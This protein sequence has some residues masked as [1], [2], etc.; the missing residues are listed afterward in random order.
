MVMIMIQNKWYDENKINELYPEAIIVPPQKIGKFPGTR[1]ITMTDVY[2]NGDYFA[3]IKKDGYCYI[4]NK[5]SNHSYLFS[6]T[7]SRTTGLPSEKG[8][9]VPHIMEYLDSVVPSNTI[10]IG[11]IY[12]PNKT[13]KDVT[14]IMGCLAP[15]AVER[16]KENKIHYYI[17]DIIMYDGKS[18]L[19]TPAIKR[20][21]YLEKIFVDECI[22]GTCPDFIEHGK[23]YQEDLMEVAS[24]ALQNGEEGIVLKKKNG[25]YYP[26]LRPAWETI[27]IKKVDTVDV[28]CLGFEDATKEYTGKETSQYWII[29]KRSPELSAEEIFE[30]KEEDNVVWTENM[31][32]TGYPQYIKSPNFRTIQVTKPWFNGWKTAMRIGVYKNGVLTQ[33]GTVSSG[34]DDFLRKD[35][36]EHPSKYVG[37]VIECEFMEK[38]ESALR[39]PIFKKF[40]EDKLAEDCKYEEIF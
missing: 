33:I 32:G 36:A 7:K 14:S 22:Y 38:G 12:Y 21:E 1:G 37:K 30:N 17:H 4:Y 19:D 15:K 11:E 10:I 20:I 18:L 39:H 29:E 34:L 35:F 27:K 28:I 25:K 5:T 13:S 2:T 6:R 26:D 23:V 31:R 8:A 3:Q 24:K 16:Q 40:R 9:N